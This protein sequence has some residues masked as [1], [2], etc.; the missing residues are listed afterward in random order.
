M[1]PTCERPA[2]RAICHLRISLLP[3]TNMW[4]AVKSR[5]WRYISTMVAVVAVVVVAVAVAAWGGGVILV[6]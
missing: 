1:A 4:R 6:F 2:P 3:R 5:S